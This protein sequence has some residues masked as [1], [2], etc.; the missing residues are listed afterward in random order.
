MS[1]A[2][3]LL[4]V[5]LLGAVTVSAAS[6]GPATAAEALAAVRHESTV[7]ITTTGRKS[8][9]P[10]TVPVWFAVDGDRVLLSTLDPSR[11]WVLNALHTPAVRLD[12]GSVVVEG[13]LRPVTDPA[14]AERITAALRQKYWVAWLAGLVGKGPAAT[15]VIDDVRVP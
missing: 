7:R 12:F 3:T 8:G 15:Y 14:L 6:G 13:R 10:H 1:R 11:D 9:K 2:S 4:G 5:L